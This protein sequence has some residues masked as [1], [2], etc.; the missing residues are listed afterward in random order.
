MLFFFFIS[1]SFAATIS[2]VSASGLVEDS[3]NVKASM[4]Q[5]RYDLGVIAVEGKIYAI[6]GYVSG[7]YVG[8]GNIPVGTNER[9]DPVTDTWA[10]LEPMLAPRPNFAIAAYQGKIYCIGGESPDGLCGT[11]EVYDIATNSWSTKAA[12]PLNNSFMKAHVIGGKIFVITGYDLLMYDPV[13]DSWT[14]KATM[15][16]A[17]ITGVH[18]AVVDN[19]IVAACL[20]FENSTREH[21]KILIY[22]PKTDVWSAGAESAFMLCYGGAGATTGV[23]AP[24]RVHVLGITTAALS[25]VPSPVNQVY[26]P[27]RDTWSTVKVMPTARTHFG[28]AVVNDVLYVIGGILDVS[29][30]DIPGPLFLTTSPN[31]ELIHIHV[32][33][34]PFVPTAVNE[35]Y[36][37]MGYSSTPIGPEPTDILFT[38]ETWPFENPSPYL[39][40]SIVT[41]IIGTVTVVLVFYFKKK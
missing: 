21:T 8:Y 23:Y 10:T 13:T 29:W 9:Y 16:K 34:Q 39:L 25:L 26:D 2:P 32:P 38:S 37:P 4:S 19:K 5:A 35:Q 7:A 18:S 40:V 14:N 41:I 1:G 12:M 24:K 31:D 27:I 30:Q 33:S 17:L 20:L 3:W 28:M 15:P 11:N 22:D 36:V 6:G